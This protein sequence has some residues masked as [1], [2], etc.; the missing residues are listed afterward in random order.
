[1][2]GAAVETKGRILTEVLPRITLV[3]VT[4]VLMKRST[5]SLCGSGVGGGG[6][7][8]GG[9]G[10]DTNKRTPGI[11]GKAKA[12]T[13]ATSVWQLYTRGGSEHE[14]DVVSGI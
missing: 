12:A 2:P 14:Y 7:G 10:G 8:G 4:K 9:S 13:D 11:S 3:G 6:G 5:S 1:M